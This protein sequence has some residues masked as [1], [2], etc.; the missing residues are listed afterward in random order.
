MG[1]L[2]FISNF[3]SDTKVDPPNESAR[4]M[5]SL[6]S[7]E[8]KVSNEKH[9]LFDL[10]KDLAKVV[11]DELGIERELEKLDEKIIRYENKIKKALNDQNEALA[12]EI[13]E[14]ISQLM[15][16]KSRQQKLLEKIRV[17]TKIIK[18]VVNEKES[19]IKAAEFELSSIKTMNNIQTMSS[20]VATSLS[21]HHMDNSDTM[22]KNLKEKWLQQQDYIEAIMDLQ[23]ESNDDDLLEKLRKEG[24]NI[25][26]GSSEDILNKLRE[27]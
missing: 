21:N 27:K 19:N 13:S 17:H 11:A 6:E 7:F 9:K 14:Q 16:D 4:D 10:K 1:I 24:I 12:I 5:E 15:N 23:K 25:G 2:R 3:F 20:T 26:K 8:K 18:T 22:F